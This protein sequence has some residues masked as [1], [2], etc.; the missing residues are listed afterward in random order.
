MHI[1]KQ[2]NYYHHRR[3]QKVRFH[4]E[5]SDIWF[6]STVNAVKNGIYKATNLLQFTDFVALEELY[7]FWGITPFIEMMMKPRVDISYDDPREVLGW[8]LI[9]GVRI[10][11]I[12]LVPK[13]DPSDNSV[14]VELVYNE[15]PEFCDIR[16]KMNPCFGDSVASE[17]LSLYTSEGYDKMRILY[18]CSQWYPDWEWDPVKFKRDRHILLSSNV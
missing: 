11:D 9:M 12:E 2:G 13:I 17:F 14:Y 6:V 15:L 16:D 7:S 18:G 3:P 4:D 10:V 1:R 5:L 8:D